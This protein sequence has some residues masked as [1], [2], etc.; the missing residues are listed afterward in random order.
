VKELYVVK[1]IIGPVPVKK[2]PAF[3]ISL[4]LLN[5]EK[6]SAFSGPSCS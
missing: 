2:M 4:L 5:F 1:M 6:I 3:M